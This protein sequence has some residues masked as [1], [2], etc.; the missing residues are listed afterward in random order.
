MPAEHPSRILLK[1]A[2]SY[3][4][5]QSFRCQPSPL[6]SQ[7]CS[8]TCTPPLESSGQAQ[9]KTQEKLKER[10]LS[11]DKH[12]NYFI[13]SILS[14]HIWFY[15]SIKQTSALR[16]ALLWK[17][18]VCQLNFKVCCGLSW[19]THRPPQSPPCSEKGER[20]R[21]KAKLVGQEKDCLI[22]QKR[23]GKQE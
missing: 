2:E 12:D 5:R 20:L 1:A 13:A 14:E 4:C 21:K 6:L 3:S 22:G 18:S 23:K 8:G 19:Q 10:E 7:C 16:T 9:T 15:I 17:I 11:K